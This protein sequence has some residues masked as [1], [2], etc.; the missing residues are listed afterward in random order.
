MK[1]LSVL[2]ASVIAMG[3]YTMPAR[4]LTGNVQDLMLDKVMCLNTT[5]GASAVGT[6]SGDG[7][8]DCGG[9]PVGADEE[10]SIVLLGTS[11][12]GPV[13][14]GN[15]IVE[16]E[17]NNPQPQD[18]GTLSPDCS[19]SV[20]GN[21]SIGYDDFNKQNPNADWDIYGFAPQGVSEL[22]VQVEVLS[23]GEY[24]LGV[25]DATTMQYLQCQFTSD[26]TDY[27][28]AIPAQTTRVLVGVGTQQPTDYTLTMSGKGLLDLPSGL[29][30]QSVQGSR[31]PQLHKVR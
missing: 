1:R 31:A 29:S 10:I 21:I 25:R 3:L 26:Y 18:A 7:E 17:P 4:A 23:K 16:Q 28:C 27:F 9:L 22:H 13:D 6:F 15:P 19:V 12:P 11:S 20:T 8:F 2:A 30:A 14:C 24:A 5:T